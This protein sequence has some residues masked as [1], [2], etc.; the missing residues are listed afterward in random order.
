MLDLIN[1]ERDRVT[2]PPVELGNEP[3]AQL[4][5]ESAL[6]NCF[7]GHWG[8]D[9]LKPYMRYSLAGGYQANAENVSGLSYC[10]NSPSYS[11]INTVEQVKVTMAGFMDSSDHRKSILNPDFKRVTIGLAWDTYNFRAVQVFEGDYIEFDHLPAIDERGVLSLSGRFRHGN[12]APE[13]F[14]FVDIYYDPPPKPLTGGQIARTY[15]VDLGRKAASLRK[16]PGRNA[17]Y[18]VH[19]YVQSTLGDLCIDPH[20]QE[21]VSPGSVTEAQ[22]LHLRARV[23]NPPVLVRTAVDWV[24]GIVWEFRGDR[25]RVTADLDDVIEDYGEGVYTIVLWGDTP[26]IAPHVA[27]QYSIFHGIDPPGVDNESNQ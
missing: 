14:S 20:E 8:I 4:H 2:V 21:T 19:Q 16:P 27:G 18:E 26:D 11:R 6:E 17:R 13:G 1:E 12:R 23:G 15:C 7:T 5:A 22:L 24:D 9:G 10:I 25:F 3:T